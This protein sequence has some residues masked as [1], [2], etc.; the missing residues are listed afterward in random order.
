[1]NEKISIL[2]ADDNAEFAKTLTSYIEKEEDMQVVGLAKDGN[3]AV[4]MIK[5]VQPDIAIL[6]V[7][8]PHLDGLGVLEKVVEIDMPKTNLYNVISSRTRQNNS[9]SS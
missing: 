4:S 7:I 6:D 5:N 3:E 9:K 8:M 2:I 1:M